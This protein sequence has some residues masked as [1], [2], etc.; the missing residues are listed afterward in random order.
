MGRRPKK[1]AIGKRNADGTKARKAPKP[2]HDDSP[3]GAGEAYSC[4][5][6]RDLM[7]VDEEEGQAAGDEDANEEDWCDED[8][9]S[10]LSSGGGQSILRFA[11]RGLVSAVRTAGKAARKNLK[12]IAPSRLDRSTIFRRRIQVEGRENV[13]LGRSM[14]LFLELGRQQQQRQQ[15]HEEEEEE[16]GSPSCGSGSSVDREV[17]PH[18]GPVCDSSGMPSMCRHVG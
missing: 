4:D 5:T 16:N 13:A 10:A 9:S 6:G 14:A 2:Q 1:K 15:Q 17:A 11:G 3:A 12:K 18:T 8:P 7:D